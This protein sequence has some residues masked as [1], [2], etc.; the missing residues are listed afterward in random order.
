MEIKRLEFEKKELEIRETY[1]DSDGC[2]K[3]R[4]KKILVPTGKVKETENTK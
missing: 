3:E 2:E 4:I 1:I